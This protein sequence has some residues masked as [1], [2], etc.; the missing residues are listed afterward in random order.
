MNHPSPLPL[1]VD[2]DGTLTPVDTLVESYL[3]LVR[4]HP[5]QA[6]LAPLWLARGRAHLKQRI[7]QLTTVDA[8]TLPLREDLLDYL[9]AARQSG[10][11]LVLATAANDKIARSV[12]A[13]VGLFDDCIGSDGQHNLKGSAKLERIRQLVGPDFA[14]AGDSPADLPIWRASRAAV[15]V[16]VSDRV[17]AEVRATTPI[18]REFAAPQRG[19]RLWFRALRVHH[20]LKNLLVF[21]P[22]LTSF[23]FGQLDKVVA[24]VVAFVAM[25]LMASGTYLLNDMWDLDNDRRHPRKRHRPLASGELPMLWGLGAATVLVAGA[26]LL[27]L[28]VSAGLLGMVLFYLAFTTLYSWSLKRQALVDVIA[29]ALLYTL[30]VLVGAVAIAVQVT[31]WLLAFSMFAFVSLALVKRCSELVAARGA[32]HEETNVR[33]YRPADLDVLLPLGVGASLCSIVVFGLFAATAIDSHRYPS[34]M[35]LWLVA[36][37]MFYWMGRLWLMTMRGRMHDDPLVFT[38]RD[39]ASRTALAAMV[40]TTAAAHFI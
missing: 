14:Y 12:A 7:A 38:L 33:G 16:N 25:S 34:A 9:K 10:R 13:R 21:L 1:V 18:E 30:R 6:L 37:G 32:G 8:D 28:Q 2:L 26:S 5:F 36:I 39:G 3:R 22:L 23:S 15:L 24:A 31:P 40:L 20:W 27:A 17:A 35:L 19:G 4:H 29:L 11:R